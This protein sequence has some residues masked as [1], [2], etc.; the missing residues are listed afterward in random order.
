MAQAC[1]Q[2]LTLSIILIYRPVG[3]APIS[4][5]FQVILFVR[6]LT[7]QS[8]WC[9]HVARIFAWVQPNGVALALARCCFPRQWMKGEAIVG[10]P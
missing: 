8:K 2:P 7:C 5:V 3:V 1:L 6:F 4:L 9:S 10:A